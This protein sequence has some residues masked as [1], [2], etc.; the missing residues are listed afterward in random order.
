MALSGSI[1]GWF[2]HAPFLRRAALRRTLLATLLCL[3]ALLTFYPERYRAASS[4]TPTDPTSLGL[5]GTL[6]QLGAVGSVFGNQTAVEVSLKVA[7]SEYVRTRVAKQL[8]LPA[9]LGMSDT[10]THRWLDRHVDIRALRGGILQFEAKDRNAELAR[11]L[12]AAY[13]EAVR[14]QLATIARNQTGLKRQILERLVNQASDQ[15]TKAQGAYD[16]FRLQ[17][18]Y[19]SPQT[20]ISAAGARIP[21]LESLIRSKK[22]ALETL[23]QFATDDNYRV[24]QLIVEIATL[25]TQLEDARSS[26]PQDK[27]SVGQVVAQSTKLERLRRDLDLAQNLYDNYKRF[28]QGTSVENLTSSANIRI[29]EPAYIDTARQFNPLPLTLGIIILLFGLAIEFYLARPPVRHKGN[30]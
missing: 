5:S 25:Q 30:V 24:R 21:E 12:V 14:E 29:L 9:K 19:S 20:A 10:E 18:R 22:V 17:T 8:G 2:A 7:R 11:S 15:L 4:L 1:T 26:S 16:S 23:R 13:G 28:L 6:G 3:C 27:S